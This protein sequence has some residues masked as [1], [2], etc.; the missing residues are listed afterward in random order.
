MPTVMIAEDDLLMADMLQDVLVDSGYDVCGIARTVATAVELGDRQRPDL[1]ILDVKLAEGGRGTEIPARL[2]DAG[3]MGILYASG[4]ADRINLTKANGDAFIGKPYRSEDIIHA[5]KIVEQIVST[6][7]ASPPFPPRFS[8]LKRS[9]GATAPAGAGGDEDVARLLRQQQALAKFGTFAFIEANMQNVLTEAARA[10]AEGLGVP[11]CKVC[12]YREDENDLLIQAG[13]GWNPGLIGRVISRADDTSPQGRAFVTG[14]PVVCSDIR[15]DLTYLLPR[16]YAEHGIISTIDVIIQATGR[17]YGVLE[18]DSPVERAFDQH[19]IDFLTGFAN[20]LAA[21]VES[22]KRQDATQIAL[23]D[24]DQLLQAQEILLDERGVLARELQHR[25]RNNLQLV[26]GMLDKQIQTTTDKAAAHGMD[27]I[28][29]RVMTLAEVYDH[30]L[31]VGLRHQVEFHRYLASLCANLEAMEKVRHPAVKLICHLSPVNLDL[32]SVTA[33]GLIVSELVANSFAH[34]FPDG[35]GSIHLSLSMDEAGSDSATIVFSDDGVGF[36]DSGNSKRNGLALVKRLIEQIGG[37]AT[38]RSDHG[39]EWT[40]KFPVPA[41]EVPPQSPGD[42]PGSR[43]EPNDTTMPGRNGPDT[44][45]PH[46]VP[47]K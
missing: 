30:L 29:R 26:Y 22:A 34:A 43:P 40:L 45:A 6:G 3:R 4:H 47:T 41:I 39:T 21:A 15:R 5:L 13:I 2:K 23:T 9:N 24:R 36:T 25:V 16:F 19:D 18:A 37:S 12:R 32:E 46:V 1:A 8:V 17:P 31:G 10:C 7:K 28:A 14:E 33:L 44:D 38:V 11:F 27:A 42:P 35:A 20:V